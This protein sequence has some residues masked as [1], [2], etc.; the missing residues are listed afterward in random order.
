MSF[1]KAEFTPLGKN[2]DHAVS[3]YVSMYH[4]RGIKA[5]ERTQKN[6]FSI[7]IL[8][9]FHATDIYIYIYIYIYILR[10]AVLP[11]GGCNKEPKNFGVV[12]Y[13]RE[14]V[15]FFVQFVGNKN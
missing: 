8:Y 1:L 4:I 7:L 5:S 14:E 13:I 2:C 9:L 12:S 6:V 10:K 11:A 3:S 15:K